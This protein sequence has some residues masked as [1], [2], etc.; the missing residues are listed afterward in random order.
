CEA[1]LSR[2]TSEETPPPRRLTARSRDFAGLHD[3]FEPPQIL[4]NAGLRIMAEKLHQA[5]AESAAEW[6]VVPAHTDDGA[7][8]GRGRLEPDRAGVRG[9]G[10]IE[11]APRD[12]FPRAVGSDFGGPLQTR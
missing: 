10:V 12:L 9:S 11:R 6:A 4:A 8:A 1:P 2:D 7:P 5:R 3:L